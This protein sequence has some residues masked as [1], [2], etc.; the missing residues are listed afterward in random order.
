MDSHLNLLQG[1]WAVKSLEIDGMVLPAQ[2]FANAIL[3]VAGDRFTS[4]GMGAEYA[5]SIV[6]NAATTP[7][8]MDMCFDAGPEKGNTNL[9]IYELAG[10]ALKLC[11]ATR[12]TVRPSAFATT[13]G[14]GIALETLEKA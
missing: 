13:P 12:G 3:E 4:Y 10:G 5:G 7:P 14:S 1:R 11:I 8:Q 6:V 9:A 2:V